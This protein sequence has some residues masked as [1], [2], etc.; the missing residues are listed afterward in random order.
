MNEDDADESSSC[1]QLHHGENSH[2][3]NRVRKFRKRVK[4]TEGKKAVIE[5]QEKLTSPLSGIVFDLLCL[6]STVAVLAWSC[7]N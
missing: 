7:M 1:Q 4:K 5:H 6:D 3:H 2:S